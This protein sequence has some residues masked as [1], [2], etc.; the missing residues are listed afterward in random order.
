MVEGGG[1][2]EQDGEAGRMK[3]FFFPAFP[4]ALGK[5]EPA[6]G[7]MSRGDGTV[8]R[9]LLSEKEPSP[10][11]DSIVLPQS[12]PPSLFPLSPFS[13]SSPHPFQ[14]R[15]KPGFSWPKFEFTRVLKDKQVKNKLLLHPV[16]LRGISYLQ[17]SPISNPSWGTPAKSRF[18]LLL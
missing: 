15:G 6:C 8:K 12:S 5:D 1:Y 10:T 7:N 18:P 4:F 16:P 13:P 14:S 11:L 17:C 9:K 2:G 3:L